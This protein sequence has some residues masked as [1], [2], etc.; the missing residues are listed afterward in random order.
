MAMRLHLIDGSGYIYRAYYGL[1]PLTR[2]DGLPVGAIYGY[3]EM[4]RR[5]IE[6]RT[7]THMAVI[8]DGGRSGRQAIDPDYKT[9]RPPRPVDLERQ[10]EHVVD[11]AAAFGVPSVRADGWEADD[12]IA[13]Y[14]RQSAS[15]GGSVTIVSSDK[16]LLQLLTEPGVAIYDPSPTKRQ[17]VDAAACVQRMGVPPH[18]VA[19]LLALMGDAS[20]NIPGVPSIGA[21]TAAALLREHGTLAEILRLASTDPMALRGVKSVQRAALTQHIEAAEVSRRLVELQHV[22]DLPDVG[23]FRCRDVDPGQLLAWLHT[24]EFAVLAQEIG[25]VSA[26]AA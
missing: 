19:D 10:L 15:G 24:M 16:D 3:C 20:D 1:P 9:T 12:V 17:F 22:P 11:A 23:T 7:C 26:V 25:T 8:L 2:S 4:L 5:L 14:A 6:A 18:Q 21:K 13:T